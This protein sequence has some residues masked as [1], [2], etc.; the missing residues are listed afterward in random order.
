M[1]TSLKFNTPGKN[2]RGMA[3]LITAMILLMAITLMTFSSAKVGNMEQKIAANDYRAKQALHAAQ[4]ALELAIYDANR[5]FADVDTGPSSANN[6]TNATLT[7][8][9]VAGHSNRYTY[10]YS[11]PLGGGNTN[12]ILITATGYS[13]DYVANANPSQVAGASKTIQQYIKRTSRLPRTPPNPL[14]TGGSYHSNSNAIDI[15]NNIGPIAIQAQGEIDTHG[16]DVTSVNGVDGAGLSPNGAIKITGITGVV[17]NS[18]ERDALFQYTFGTSKADVQSMS[19]PVT[20]NG[21][22]NTQLG[23]TGVVKSGNTITNHGTPKS[24]M[25]WVTGNTTLNSN[26]VIGSP[27]NPV[28]LVINGTL[29]I[30]G[31]VTIYGFVYVTGDIND[32]TGVDASGGA[33]LYGGMVSEK[34]LDFSGTVNI[35]YTKY[36]RN[37][38]NGGPSGPS[39]FVKVP[40]SW[41]DDV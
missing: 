31:G 11:Q 3:T 27:T 23:N 14:T 29:T 13:D 10:S 1:T 32:D 15:V 8:T 9:G 12:L 22:C 33:T 17:D 6:V 18:A 35:T 41:T 20:C 40:G 4:A 21:N 37:G 38:C 30:N 7:A 28:T 24:P 25:L 39:L 19:T 36:C 16:K 34:S 26:T 2:Q 5:L